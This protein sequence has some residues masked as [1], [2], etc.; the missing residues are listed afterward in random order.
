MS[1]LTIEV[2]MTGGP[3]NA[4]FKLDSIELVKELST[5]TTGVYL[6]SGHVVTITHGDV[7][8]A[9]FSV[10]EAI[11]TARKSIVKSGVRPMT[12]M[13]VVMPSGITA[14]AFAVA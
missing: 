10:Q 4:L 3:S 8:A 12:N 5:T 1:N 11:D 9:E 6:T 13:E 7:S 2:P 14:T